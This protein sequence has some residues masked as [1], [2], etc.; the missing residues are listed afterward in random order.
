MNHAFFPLCLVRTHT[1]FD[2]VWV[3][4]TITSSLWGLIFLALSPLSFF[5]LSSGNFL[6]Y[7]CWSVLGWRLKG[8]PLLLSGSLSV[9]LSPLWCSVLLSLSCFISQTLSFVSTPRESTR[10]HLASLSLHHDKKTPSHSKQG[11][12]EVSLHFS[13]I[14]QELLSFVFCCS[15]PEKPLCHIFYLVF[16][17]V[18]G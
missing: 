1:I 10:L 18:K 9:Q 8:D 15:L 13:S 11:Q 7:M 6:T 4:D 5:Y 12:S 16:G 17:Q 2:P 14:D 3:L